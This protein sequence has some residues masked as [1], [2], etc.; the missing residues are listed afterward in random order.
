MKKIQKLNDTRMKSMKIMLSAMLL[1]MSL[2]AF[3]QDDDEMFGQAGDAEA[4]EVSAPSTAVDKKF[5][6]RA[7]V[8]FVGTDV[9]YKNFG[10]SPAYNNYF[11]KG[12]SFGWLGDL[13]INKKLP[14]FLEFGGTFA[15]QTGKAKGDSIRI[16][17]TID[18]G[19][20]TV[21]SFRVNAFSLTIPVSISYHI[22]NLAGV[23]GLTL[24]PYA[25]LY[26]RFNLMAKRKETES[27]CEYK[28][29][30]DG[31]MIVTNT[32]ENHYTASLMS[33]DEDKR[34]FVQK[35]HVGTGVQWGAQV[36]VNAF[37]KRYSLGV[38]YMYDAKNFAGHTS[39]PELTSKP[40]G[41]GGNLPYIGTNCDESVSTHHNFAVTVG[42]IF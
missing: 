38:S 37:Y 36:G 2:G 42:Y 22:K 19:V 28:F 3:A 21:R 12:L 20:T 1:T 8:G 40:T 6:H 39:S 4:T 25:G 9:K 26:A 29:A 23:D 30:E 33:V 7:V 27:I 15:F 34:A 16:N 24:A 31:T 32:A 18:D 11:L 41:N 17:N 5:F 14:L 13:R 10:Q 35:P